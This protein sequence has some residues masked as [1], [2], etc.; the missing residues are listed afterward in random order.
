MRLL[1][2]SKGGRVEATYVLPATID[3]PQVAAGQ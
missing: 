3:F 2:Q 1:T